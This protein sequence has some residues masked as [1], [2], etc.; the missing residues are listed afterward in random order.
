MHILPNVVS[1]AIVLAATQVGV[2]ILAES[3]LSFL[4]P[5]RQAA[6]E[7]DPGA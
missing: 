7:D 3:S 6:R 5:G 4:R 2:T 1:T